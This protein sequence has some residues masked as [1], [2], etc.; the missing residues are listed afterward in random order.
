LLSFGRG[1]LYYHAAI[2]IT[3]YVS[4]GHLTASH[5]WFAS[6][7]LLVRYLPS[8]RP[9]KSTAVCRFETAE[10]ALFRFLEWPLR[11]KRPIDLDQIWNCM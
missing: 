3:L 7:R 6:V 8:V 10:E 4:C 1:N 11:W 5:R 2:T 9:I